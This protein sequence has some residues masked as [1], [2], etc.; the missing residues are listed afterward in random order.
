[1]RTTA[2]NWRGGEVSLRA[3]FQRSYTTYH[4]EQLWPVL[5]PSDLT[6]DLNH[7]DEDP[8]GADSGEGSAEDEDVDVVAASADDGSDLEDG[9]GGDED[10]FG[11]EDAQDLAE[12]QEEGSF[13]KRRRRVSAS[14]DVR[15]S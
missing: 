6:Q 5:Q 14:P 10:V 3:R 8:G 11:R 7:G 15:R 2:P 12:D 4:S 13:C 1:M 9:D